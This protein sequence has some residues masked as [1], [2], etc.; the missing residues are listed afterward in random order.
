M[1]PDGLPPWLA[2]GFGDGG[3][4]ATQFAQ[5][6]IPETVAVDAAG[7]ILVGGNFGIAR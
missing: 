1:M 4:V 5:S 7:R 3:T 6:D 2:A